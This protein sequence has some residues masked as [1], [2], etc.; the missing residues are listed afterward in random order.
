MIQFKRLGSLEA[1]KV[2]P[3]AST[4]IQGVCMSLW[5][6]YHDFILAWLE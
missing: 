3:A 1:E 5:L 4:D 6:V 2:I